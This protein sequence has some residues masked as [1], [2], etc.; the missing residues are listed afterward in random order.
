MPAAGAASRTEGRSGGAIGR[1]AGFASAAF[2]SAGWLACS[3]TSVTGS[4]VPE[5][6]RSCTRPFDASVP[7]DG[8]VE[9]V[10]RCRKIIATSSSTE[11]EC[12]FFSCT[13]SSGSMSMMTPGL[14]SSSLANSL[15]RIFF[16]E[17]TAR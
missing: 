15:I 4:S 2:A 11:L 17:E 1:V 8:V 7:S 14:T 3:A 10:R 5:A 6:G 13:P 9:R 12:V 16:I